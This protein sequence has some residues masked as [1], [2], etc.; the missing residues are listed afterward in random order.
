[1]HVERRSITMDKRKGFTLIELLVV[2]AIIAI[3]MAIL[4]PTLNK[5]RE[6]GK[7]AACLSNLKQLT[8]A[9]IMYADENDGKLVKARVGQ[10]DNKTGR[11][12][13]WVGQPGRNEWEAEKIEHIKEGLL[14]TYARNIKLYRCPTG[15]RGELVTYSIVASMAGDKPH[16]RT[17]ATED[18]VFTNKIQIRRP[19]ERFV[20]VDDGKCPGTGNTST[21]PWDVGYT[22]RMWHDKPTVRHGNGTNWS[23]ADGHSEYYKWR[24]PRTIELANDPT[25]Y[26][27]MCSV[28]HPDSVDLVWATKGVW[29]RT[30]YAPL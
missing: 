22:V 10:K 3:L 17:G 5:A 13:G 4:V 8:L 21:S 30:N 1:M 18:M 24:D 19:G 2:I 12:I 9:W 6:M 25:K 14:F 16:N 27:S 20:F 23:F 7:R 15:I 29:G 11:I 28:S 26:D